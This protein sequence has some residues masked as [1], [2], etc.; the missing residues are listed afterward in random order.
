MWFFILLSICT[1]CPSGI[2][3]MRVWVRLRTCRRTEPNPHAESHADADQSAPA[4]PHA[5]S[6]ANTYSYPNTHPWSDAN[7]RTERDARLAYAV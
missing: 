2:D 7:S 3:G 4:E 5:H 1:S 6:D